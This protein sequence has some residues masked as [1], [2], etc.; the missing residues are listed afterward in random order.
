VRKILL[1]TLTASFALALVFT[2]SCGEHNSDGGGG[3]GEE[4]IK[5]PEEEVVDPRIV[6]IYQRIDNGQ[7]T[8]G[9]PTTVQETPEE[10]LVTGSGL[11]ANENTYVGFGINIFEGPTVN[12]AVKLPLLSENFYALKAADGSG[13]NPK[14]TK[15]VLASTE[16]NVAITDKLQ[17]SFQKFNINA[18]VSTNTPFFSGGISA[19]YGSQ[20]EVGSASKFYNA[21][22]YRALYK[23]TISGTYLLNSESLKGILDPEF[24]ELLNNPAIPPDL[25]FDVYG[26][27]IILQSSVGGSASITAVYNSNT[28]ASETEIGAALSFE[29]YW[30][31]GN[32]NTEYAERYKSITSSTS[33]RVNME[34][35]GVSSLPSQPAVKDMKP[36]LDSWISNIDKKPV[37]A[38]VE[39]AIPIWL[40]ATD[41][42]RKA[43][44]EAEFY[45]QVEERNVYLE[46]FFAKKAAPQPIPQPLIVDGQV[47]RI[48]NFRSQKYMTVQ[49]ESK[50]E[51]AIVWLW[52][53]APNSNAMKWKA[54][55]ASDRPGWFYF[56]NLNSGMI[57]E[58]HDPYGL[59]HIGNMQYYYLTQVNRNGRDDQ[60][61]KALESGDNK[62][63]FIVNKSY[64]E[65]SN[66]YDNCSLLRTFSDA[67]SN[68]AL[69]YTTYS[70]Y[71]YPEKYCDL[72]R[73]NLPS[74]PARNRWVLEKVE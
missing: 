46:G 41:P 35:G 32:V 21:I 58:H 11:P 23:H 26:T 15:Q 5:P 20:G 10:G 54:M 53:L 31:S 28:V 1:K 47:Y 29:S 34:G 42:T 66:Y 19:S 72:T 36:M 49:N 74:E 45:K 9:V 17:E 2:F 68:G 48:M 4:D 67:H 12:K 16:Y 63:I 69:I 8:D 73:L 24:A 6:N 59:Q 61:Y 37:L 39:K 33:L 56:V 52:E 38:Y 25:L 51:H 64:Y 57:I 60:L 50:S 55:E 44:L 65:S 30:A 13:E 18:G 14:I 43:A 40:L 7:Y 71:G 3:G 27:H 70:T 22:C 62:S